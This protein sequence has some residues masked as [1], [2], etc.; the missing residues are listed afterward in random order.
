MQKLSGHFRLTPQCGF[1][2][3]ELRAFL[4]CERGAL[5]VELVALAL[6]LAIGAIAITGLMMKGL[7]T[8][9]CSVVQQL[10]PSATCG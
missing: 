2:W 4:R 6:I 8:P 7:A 10:S 1:G 5:T 9:A 3:K